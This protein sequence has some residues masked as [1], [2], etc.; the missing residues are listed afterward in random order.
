[1][2]LHLKLLDIDHPLTFEKSKLRQ[3][4]AHALIYLRD[5]DMKCLQKYPIH[6]HVQKIWLI[7]HGGI[8]TNYFKP[9]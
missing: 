2:S 6:L 9:T 1:M 4:E 5:S 3:I 8:C 7:W